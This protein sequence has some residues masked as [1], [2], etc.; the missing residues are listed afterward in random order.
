[1]FRVIPRVEAS[2]SPFQTSRVSTLQTEAQGDPL[3][4]RRP[5]ES[6]DR[7]DKIICKLY[8]DR[9]MVYIGV[10]HLNWEDSVRVGG[11][12]MAR[13]V[14]IQRCERAWWGSFH[15]DRSRPN[16]ENPTVQSRWPYY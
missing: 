5:L 3:D 1:M 13:N 14:M 16:L 9:G 15:R 8:V 10:N 2:S 4:T 7:T 11:I 12:A 6:V